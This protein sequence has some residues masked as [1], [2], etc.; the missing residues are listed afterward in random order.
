MILI[1]AVR[2]AIRDL[3]TKQSGVFR[4]RFFVLASHRLASILKMCDIYPTGL[5]GSRRNPAL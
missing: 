1:L 2:F 3:E 4:Q 5:S